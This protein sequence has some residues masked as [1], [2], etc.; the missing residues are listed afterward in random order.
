MVS[1]RLLFLPEIRDLRTENPR[2]TM[3]GEQA[4]QVNLVGCSGLVTGQSRD[5]PRSSGVLIPESNV[6][7][8]CALYKDRDI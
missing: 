5:L 6:I 7:S 2:G 3:G 4:V 8:L 1:Q